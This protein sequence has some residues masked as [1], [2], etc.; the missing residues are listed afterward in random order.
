MAITACRHWWWPSHQTWSDW[1]STNKPVDVQFSIV[2]GII[3]FRHYGEYSPILACADIEMTFTFEYARA[4]DA[5][6]ALFSTGA[7]A[8]DV[9]I[10]SDWLRLDQYLDIPIL[11]QICNNT[12]KTN[13]DE[14]LWLLRLQ[15]HEQYQGMDV[16]DLAAHGQ[17][18][19]LKWLHANGAC[20]LTNQTLLSAKDNLETANW[21][22]NI[23]NLKLSEYHLEHLE[24]LQC[25]RANQWHVA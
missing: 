19:T 14:N 18:Q 13:S 6:S 20:K 10:L 7:I 2:N 16:D 3:P 21:I 9:N 1:K 8:T 11:R 25:I 4:A 24:A 22:S 17:L 23:L 15:G 12:W 5:L